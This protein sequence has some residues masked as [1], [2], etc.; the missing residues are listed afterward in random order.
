MYQDWPSK[1]N[2]KFWGE[3]KQMFSLIEG[4]ILDDIF[5]FT[6]N[7]LKLFSQDINALREWDAGAEESSWP[8]EDQFYAQQIVNYPLL[9]HFSLN[10]MALFAFFLWWWKFEAY[11]SPRCVYT[12]I[13]WI[14]FMRVHI[15]AAQEMSSV[16][17]MD[18]T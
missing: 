9:R 15:E 16:S 17:F 14:F 1:M 10:L 3:K 11:A 4:L 13:A 7:E 2:R 6:L 18:I 12:G 5:N 8:L